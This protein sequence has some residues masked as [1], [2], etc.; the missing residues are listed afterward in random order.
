MASTVIAIAMT[1]SYTLLA[2][3][4]AAKFGTGRDDLAFF[5]LIYSHW[6]DG[7]T[8]ATFYTP[9]S[10]Y[11]YFDRGFSF[12]A[13]LANLVEINNKVSDNFKFWVRLY[14]HLRLSGFSAC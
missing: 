10:V 3:L 12:W 6:A 4:T 14:D 5:S 9:F 7:H 1:I 11:G 2:C 13:G 8:I